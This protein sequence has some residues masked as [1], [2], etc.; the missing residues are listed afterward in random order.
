M[1]LSPQAVLLDAFQL[2]HRNLRAAVL[3]LTPEQLVWRP[4]EGA[5]SVAF[6][7]WHVPRTTDFYI[8]RRLRSEPELWSRDNWRARIPI[9]AE[10]QGTRGLGIGSGFTDQQVGAMPAL[11]PSQYLAYLDVVAAQVEAWL[12]TLAPEEL[13]EER[14][15]EGFQKAQVLRVVLAALGHSHSHT[16]EIGYVKGLMGMPGRA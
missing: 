14:E 2:A 8:N 13:L 5:N 3:D 15:R 4:Q 6:Y 7:L 10:G 16:G 12:T 11:P 9:E 1:P